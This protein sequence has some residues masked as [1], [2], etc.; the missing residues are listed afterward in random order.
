MN[1]FLIALV[2]MVLVPIQFTR[3]VAPSCV[4]IFAV[5]HSII[6]ELHCSMFHMQLAEYRVYLRVMTSILKLK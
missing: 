5:L 3:W 4:C 1:F 6:T 2:V